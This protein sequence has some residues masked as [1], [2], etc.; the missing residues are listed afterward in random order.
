MNKGAEKGTVS[1]M[2]D[3]T[4]ELWDSYNTRPFVLG[5]RDGT[6][7]RDRF[8]YYILQDYLY[9]EEYAK[10]FSIGIAKARSAEIM[11]LFSTYVNLLTGSEMDIHRGY[12]GR[13]AISQE[14]IESTPRALC[15]LSYTSYMLRV[16]YEEGEAEILTA[17][18][19]CCTSYE[20]IAKRMVAENPACLSDPFYG[21]WIQGYSSEEYADAN[22]KMEAALDALTI[23][24]TEPQIQH[25]IDIF[26]VCS[27]Y[28][29]MFWDMGWDMSR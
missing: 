4:K 8:R 16:A 1:R 18:L 29:G 11:S 7:S 19:P 28:E 21:E 27:R 13:F 24:Y 22:R 5:M 17:V 3:A 9:I 6:L 12:I 26:T 2:I 23:S 10:V 15:N 25:L 14:E 20:V